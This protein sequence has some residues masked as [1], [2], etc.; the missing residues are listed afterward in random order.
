MHYLQPRYFRKLNIHQDQIGVVLS[1]QGDRLDTVLGL[2][3]A[4]AVRHEQIVE[5][6]H[7]EVVILD[8]QDLLPRERIGR[9]V[10]FRNFERHSS[11]ASRQN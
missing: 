2:Q 11:P 4:I 3:C 7:I 8:D 6:L 10:Q 1:D 5:E 9:P